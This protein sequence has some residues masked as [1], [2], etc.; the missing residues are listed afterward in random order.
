VSQPPVKLPGQQS[1][2]GWKANL[3]PTKTLRE[4]AQNSTLAEGPAVTRSGNPYGCSTITVV[5]QPVEP[6]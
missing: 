6:D 3:T 1:L 2:D 5:E 4:S